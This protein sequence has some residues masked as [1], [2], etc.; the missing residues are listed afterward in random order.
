MHRH[1]TC[2]NPHRNVSVNSQI[3]GQ[4]KSHECSAVEGVPSWQ[5]SVRG[6]GGEPLSVLARPGPRPKT[7]QH[8]GTQKTDSLS[9][10]FWSKHRK[11]KHCAFISWHAPNVC[12]L[13]ARTKWGHH[14]TFCGY[15]T[16]YFWS[17]HRYLGLRCVR[18]ARQ[19]VLCRKLKSVHLSSK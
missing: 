16:N 17:V 13:S 6:E 9:A 5:R 18:N 14:N 12:S 7:K 10:C 8:L 4:R 3:G 15:R 2:K 1:N 11:N 19:T